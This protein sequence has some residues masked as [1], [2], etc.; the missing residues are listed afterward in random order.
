MPVCTPRWDIC[1]ES[2][3][4]WEVE[5]L[6]WLKW[7]SVGMAGGS[8]CTSMLSCGVKPLNM[9][10]PTERTWRCRSSGCVF[11][12]IEHPWQQDLRRAPCPPS[13]PCSNSSQGTAPQS[14]QPAA[15]LSQL[16]NRKKIDLCFPSLWN[17][18]VPPLSR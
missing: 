2:E 6:S 8:R 7:R 15:F 9:D 10:L 13:H 3:I 11:A 1:G 12:W 17:Y 5:A 18:H 16:Q 14:C 4:P